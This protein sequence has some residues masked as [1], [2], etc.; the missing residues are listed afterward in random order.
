MSAALAINTNPHLSTRSW[1]AKPR[2][3]VVDDS[4]TIL[5]AICSLL[6]HREIVD[7]VGRAESGQETI[8]S[9]SDLKPD[10]VLIDAD[11]PSMSGLRTSLLL[12]QSFPQTRVVLMSMD[13]TAQF[14]RA[15]SGC[16]AFAVIYKPKFLSELFKLLHAEPDSN[17]QRSARRRK[18]K[19]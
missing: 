4:P 10:L 1:P 12:T 16:G 15:C 2:A 6:E 7:V 18:L 5:H 17:W 19:T 9:V 8:R 13:N 3:L 11:M 14:R